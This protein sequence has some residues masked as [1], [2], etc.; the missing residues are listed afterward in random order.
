[1]KLYRF[2]DQKWLRQIEKTGKMRI[3]F[4][5]D[6]EEKKHGKERGDDSE[7]KLREIL[8]IENYN[9]STSRNPLFFNKLRTLGIDINNCSNITMKNVTLE[10]QHIVNNYF[11]M[12]SCKEKDLA[13]S[14]KF[15]KG[16]LVINNFEHF[17][18]EVNKIMIRKGHSYFRH[19]FCKYVPKREIIQNENY[20]LPSLPHPAFLKEE[21]YSYQK[22]HRILWMP[23]DNFIIKTPIDIVC[24]KAFKYCDFIYLKE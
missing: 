12:C 6:Y 18:K 7:G 11:V 15:G 22:E 2:M 16:I 3:N 21:R 4:L 5:N 10:T 8:S 9:G 1:M 24:K 13:L 20:F 23:K 19:D 14:K 17:L